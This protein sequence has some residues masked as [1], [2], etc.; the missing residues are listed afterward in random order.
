MQVAL[1][2][3]TVARAVSPGAFTRLLAQQL[4]AGILKLAI[5]ERVTTRRE[6]P[7][8]TSGA[9]TRWSVV[10]RRGGAIDRNAG[11]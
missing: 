5:P 4:S 7:G 6:A 2:K 3:G 8:E 11:G 9:R 10:F 1:A